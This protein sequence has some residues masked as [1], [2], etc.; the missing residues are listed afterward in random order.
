MIHKEKLQ[1]LLDGEKTDEQEFLSLLEAD[2]ALAESFK[3][4]L[5]LDC[6]LKNKSDDAESHKRLEDAVFQ[7]LM[8]TQDS[9]IKES[10]TK[11]ESVSFPVQKRRRLAV[12]AMG[13]AACACLGLFI[14]Y[15]HF[16]YF[17][18]AAGVELSAG[19][20]LRSH[21]KSLLLKSSDG[22]KL[23]LQPGTEVRVVSQGD[24]VS[25]YLHKGEINVEIKPR[26][27]RPDFHFLTEDTEV[28]VTGTAFRIG[29]ENGISFLKVIRGE[30]EHVTEG[31]V[32]LVSKGQEVLNVAGASVDSQILKERYLASRA[33]SQ[34]PVLFELDLKEV[35]Q[36]LVKRNGRFNKKA[37]NFSEN[38][39]YVKDYFDG[40]N[41]TSFSAVTWINTALLKNKVQVIV[42]Q[43][44]ALTADFGGWEFLIRPGGRLA[45]MWVKAASVGVPRWGRI[46]GP[47]VS[48][49]K[50][51][52]VAVSIEADR[53]VSQQAVKVTFYI[54]GKKI[55]SQESIIK[56]PREGENKLI[57]GRFGTEDSHLKEGVM[58]GFTG[59]IDSFT[60]Y[61]EVLQ[62]EEIHQLYELG[63]DRK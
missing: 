20:V 37:L 49:K 38:K 42:T 35:P 18:T 29:R 15:S 58:H 60:M 63:K 16:A 8:M 23:T 28:R 10:V 40:L 7:E 46:E 47:E 39:A 4:Q 19:A 43:R 25:F 34:K 24:P 6:L 5:L 52:Q 57:F 13:L 55:G 51:T 36:E 33:L 27:L 2:D 44:S 53:Q 14:F 56:M 26:L 30:V 3:E 11:S 41:S 1:R 45:F 12:W 50:W 31:K 32:R 22:D 9:L 62:D 61:S 21:D 54:D 17:K 59:A 48:L